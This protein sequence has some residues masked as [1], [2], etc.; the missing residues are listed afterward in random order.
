MAKTCKNIF[1]WKLENNFHLKISLFLNL[2]KWNFQIKICFPVFIGKCFISF[3]HLKNGERNST[4]RHFPIRSKFGKWKSSNGDR[5]SVSI[6]FAQF[7][8]SRSHRPLA[9]FIQTFRWVITRW[10]LGQ[11]GGQKFSIIAFSRSR[12]R[13]AKSYRVR[14]SAQKILQI[15]L[16]F[17]RF[18]GQNAGTIFGSHFCQI[19]TKKLF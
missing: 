12:R 4:R 6:I 13:Y 9:R 1:R 10:I 5:N 11:F 18:F 3:G 17:F 19:L 16:F 7:P 15:F 14:I 2:K 8:A